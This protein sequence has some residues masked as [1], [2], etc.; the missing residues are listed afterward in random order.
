MLRSGG[1]AQRSLR[2]EAFCPQL[3]RF[4]NSQSSDCMAV[5]FRRIEVYMRPLTDSDLQE[6][7]KTGSWKGK[8]GGYDIKGL[9]AKHIE[10]SDGDEITVLGFS[11]KAGK[12]AGGLVAD[13]LRQVKVTPPCSK[14]NSLWISVNQSSMPL[15][16]L[17]REILGLTV[18]RFECPSV[19]LEQH[20]R[21]AAIE[22]N[23]QRNDSAPS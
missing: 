4:D 5:I 17:T 10:I 18:S 6:L 22:I 21:N 12:D 13:I 7:I 2:E 20:H 11:S 16:N 8:A 9:A 23:N 15:L 19:C 14:T 1:Y 3:H